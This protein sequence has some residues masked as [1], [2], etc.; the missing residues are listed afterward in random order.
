MRDKLRTL[1]EIESGEESG[2]SMLLIQSLFLGVFLGAFDISAHSILLSTFDE[3]MMARGY[4]FS[5]IAGIIITSLYYK[6]KRKINFR[7]FAEISLSAQAVL[8][9]I[10][11]I[12]LVFSPSDRIVF[13]LFI[14]FGPVNILT[15]ICFR[16]TAEKLF[17]QKQL[18]RLSQLN[19][20]GLITGIIVISFAI[21]VLMYFKLPSY[22]ILLAGAASVFAGTVI[23]F[24]IGTKFSLAGTDNI[25]L[26]ETNEK[27][28][29]IFTVFFEDRYFRIIGIFAA[30]SVIV[31]F[32]IQYSFMAVTRQQYPAAE[33]MATFLGLFTGATLI[34]IQIFKRFGFEYFLYNFGM[35]TCLIISPVIIALLSFIVVANGFLTG[36]SP[37]AIGG[38]VLFFIFLL[39]SRLLSRTLKEIA[40]SPSLKAI[41]HPLEKNLKPGLNN[42][43]GGSLNEIMVIFSG[44]ILTVLG[45]LEFFRLLHF[46]ILM[47]CISLI[48]LFVS[49]RLYREYRKC[50]LRDRAKAVQKE[51]ESD[52]LADHNDFRNRLSAEI[53]FH[54]DYFRLITGDFP[55]PDKFS[56][57]WY[58]KG[59]IEYA[60][61]YKDLNLLP[62]LIRFANNKG[63]DEEIRRNAAEVAAFL[64]IQA[65]SEEDYEKISESVKV[66]SGTRRPQ[67]T[68]IL[69]LLRNSSHESKR[70]AIYMIG[71]F[72]LSDLL[73]EVCGCLSISGLT[74]DAYEVLKTFGP[75]AEDQLIRF[76]VVSSGNTELCKTILRLLAYTNSSDTISFLFSRL[77]SNSRQLKE[78]TVKLLINCKFTPSE[79]EKQ[80]MV[81]LVSDVIGIITWNLSAKISLV[82]EHDD[83][84]LDKVNYEIDRWT[85]FLFSIL[86]VTYGF[87]YV[88]RIRE[89]LG[90]ETKESVSYAAE[91]MNLEVSELILPKLISLFDTASDVNKPDKLFHYFP[92]EILNQRNLREDLINRDYNLISLWT[93]ACVLRSID[94]I[95]S[96][97]MGES[98]VALLFSPEEII[99][100]E[101]ANLLGRSNPEIY[102]S[103]SGRIPGSISDRVSEIIN[104]NADR[105]GFLYEKIK[106]LSLYFKGITEDDLLPLAK[107]MRYLTN[108]NA[109]PI[110]H[111]GGCIL[112]I[113]FSQK[114]YFN[115]HVFYGGEAGNLTEMNRNNQE[116]DIYLLPF[117]TIEDY[118]FHY[119]DNSY[120]ILQ[121]IDD[122]EK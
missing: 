122:N 47:F 65:E 10:L 25:Q 82:A 99:Q 60:N 93:K 115:V 97:E 96:K 76:Y 19:E 43:M 45:L 113:S 26:P 39:F 79:E 66:L 69:S 5:G 49:F 62:V 2:V 74:K 77:W 3:K 91:L 116:K 90:C 50:L 11:W 112:W 29:T 36:I 12:A 56:N 78:L 110:E 121:F 46:T 17:T 95:E 16:G 68:E 104:G 102:R 83:F 58:C 72:R 85:E 22:N 32:F 108:T 9:F 114:D 98:V 55:I 103:V 84:L 64:K 120:N 105:K 1:L 35:R 61:S 15:L 28:E 38:F 92:G 111:F 107:G 81:L 94:K 100:E 24:I 51:F 70:L 34:I 80:R 33:Q 63:L 40:E 89:V 75:D 73:P 48:W 88:A 31:A 13:M 54:R 119:P 42:L 27:R 118:H 18:K 57:I 7:Y 30:L 37:S 8:T 109:G 4:V 71:K 14:L 117:I 101:S 87:G 86:S 106:F 44:L 67:T 23:Q 53:N 6:F 59:I 21:P 20:T 41:C 52:F